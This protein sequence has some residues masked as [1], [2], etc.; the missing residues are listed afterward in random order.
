M[1]RNDIKCKDMFMFTLKNL[2]RK[3][4]RFMVPTSLTVELDLDSLYLIM[5]FIDDPAIQVI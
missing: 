2:A 3:E 4:L 1:W 5:D